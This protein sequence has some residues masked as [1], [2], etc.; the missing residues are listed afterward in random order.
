MPDKHIWI[1]TERQRRLKLVTA[2]LA[3]K[4]E[5]VQYHITKNS[6]SETIGK[7]IDEMY[8]RMEREQQS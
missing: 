2:W 5:T 3:E 1:S 6:E 8:E 7:L 4:N